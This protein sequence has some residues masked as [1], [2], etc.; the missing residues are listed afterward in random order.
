MDKPLQSKQTKILPAN[1]S[2]DDFRDDITTHILNNKAQTSSSNSNN[3]SSS[4]SKN[5]MTQNSAKHLGALDVE[6][7]AAL[8][9]H[10]CMCFLISL[11]STTTRL[12]HSNTTLLFQQCYNITLDKSYIVEDDLVFAEEV[13]N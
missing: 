11:A 8:A 13:S 4:S 7:D 2:A 1:Q 9:N 3:K 10:L 6:D 5:I 12:L